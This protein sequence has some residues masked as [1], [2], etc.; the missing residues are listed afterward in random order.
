VARCE[1]GFSYWDGEHG[2]G[3]HHTVIANNVFYATNYATVWLPGANV[4]DTTIVANNVLYQKYGRPYAVAASR[5]ITWRHNSWFGGGDPATIQRGANDVTADPLLTNPG[6]GEI[7]DYKLQPKSPLIDAGSNDGDVPADFFG[8]KRAGRG[9]AR[10]IG[11][12]EY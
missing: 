10:D 4:H 6:G 5:G 8:T 1:S 12:H 7:A 11:L 3:L 2:G 9:R